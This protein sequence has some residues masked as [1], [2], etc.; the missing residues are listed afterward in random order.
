[1][2]GLGVTLSPI[3]AELANARIASLGLEGRLSCL[4][5]DY[6]HLPATVSRADVAFA[7]ESFV[8]APDGARFFAACAA[9]VRSGGVLVICDDVRRADHTTTGP[10]AA[11]ATVDRFCRGWRINT[12]LTG[13]EMER[14]AS[15]AGLAALWRGTTSHRG[16]RYAGRAILRWRPC[17]CRWDG[18]NGTPTA[19]RH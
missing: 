15:E 7:I 2:S 18:W 1:M 4:E 8:H 13:V 12:L 6:L 14:L 16:W 5:A 11:A 3:Q 9:L 19:P 10:A 17:S